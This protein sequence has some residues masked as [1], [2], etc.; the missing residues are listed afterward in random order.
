MKQRS[1]SLDHSAHAHRRH[2][3]HRATVTV[4][5]PYVQNFL[6]KKKFFLSI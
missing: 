6:R 2:L 1:A 5:T 4:R 3:H